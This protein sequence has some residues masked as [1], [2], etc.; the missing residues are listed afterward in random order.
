M[1]L[2]RLALTI[3]ATL[4]PACA[5][6][7]GKSGAIILKD[8]ARFTMTSLS[9]GSLSRTVSVTV[10]DEKG[11]T[12]AVFSEYTGPTTILSSFYGEIEEP[13]VGVRKIKKKDVVSVSLATGLAEDGFMSVFKPSTKKYP[14]TVTYSYS[15]QYKKG[16]AVFPPYCPVRQENVSIKEGHYVISV[17]AGTVVRYHSSLSAGNP[18]FHKEGSNEVYNWTIPTYD[19]YVS[20]HNMP[21]PSMITPFIMASPDKFMFQGI[22][23]EQDS[24]ESLGRWQSQLLE[25]TDDLSPET[26]SMVRKMTESASSSLE[27]VR[28]L[29]NYLREKTRYVSVQLGIG[30]FKPK[31]ASLVERSGFGECKA[32]SNYLRSM[33]KAAGV[34]SIYIILNTSRKNFYP[35]YPSFGQT[36]HAM[37]AVPLP[38]F[39]DTL[40]IECTAPSIP[41]GYRH[42]KVAGHEVILIHPGGNGEVVRVR[43]YPDSLILSELCLNVDLQADGS[44]QLS[45][46][47]TESASNIETWINY[48]EMSPE[49]WSSML[50]GGCIL[51][52]QNLSVVN[53]RDNFE[54]YDGPSWI[55]EFSVDFNFDVRSYARA[56]SGRIIVPVNPFGKQLFAQRGD[57]VNPL[58]FNEGQSIRYHIMIHIPDGFS[59]ET[60]PKDVF[61][62]APWGQYFSKAS[63]SDDRSTVEITQEIKVTP[64]FEASSSYDNYREYTRSVNRAGNGTL[65]LVKKD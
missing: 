31:K 44:A 9:E 18:S 13:G 12:A 37:L 26:V 56:S 20:E 15:I 59:V 48:R 25:G 8:D 28:I 64:C 33:L 14:F 34:E 19:G 47:R 38:E 43:N 50:I 7:Q 29:Y 27:K 40:W 32:L 52:P 57:R 11:E 51:Q 39:H 36:D 35:S 6:S 22:S 63:I 17:P 16:F 65:V 54:T 1:K 21:S 42:D 30:G 55:P 46:T 2:L 45:A 49:R 4:L 3:A 53:K 58:V 10:F 41:L 61:L 23:G 62:Q 5:F 24:W 60:M